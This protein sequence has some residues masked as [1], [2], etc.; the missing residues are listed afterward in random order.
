MA[1]CAKVLIII[2]VFS[3][4]LKYMF[5]L[6]SM[7]VAGCVGGPGSLLICLYAPFA[8]CSWNLFV[9]SSDISEFHLFASALKAFFASLS[10]SSCLFCS[11]A[12]LVIFRFP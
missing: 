10:L 6:S 5:Y 12:C 8:S 4:G 2:F 11:S 3:S 7:G 1:V 9:I